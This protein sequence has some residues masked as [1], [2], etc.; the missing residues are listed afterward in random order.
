MVSLLHL[1]DNHVAPFFVESGPM[2][3]VVSILMYLSLSAPGCHLFMKLFN[4]EMSDT[5]KKARKRG[6]FVTYL[7]AVHNFILA[8]YSCW[9]FINT[10]PIFYRALLAHGFENVL[11]DANNDLWSQAGWW[12]THFYISKYYEFMDSWIVYLKGDTPIFLQTY[13]HAGIVLMMY[14]ICVSQSPFTGL[15]TTSFNA[16]IHTFMYTYYLFAV[17]GYKSPYAK[18][19]TMAQL[20]QFIIGI[21]ISLK[22]YVVPHCLRKQAQMIAL[23]AMHLYVLVLVY[24]FSRFFVNRYKQGN[25]ISGAKKN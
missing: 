13:H 4:L 23:C 5:D 21:S 18:Y 2:V 14:G 17:L 8:T 16:C 15:V 1:Y 10:A 22:S 11:C 3:P 6:K 12:I 9:T 25:S 19:L 7:S 24:L 20:A